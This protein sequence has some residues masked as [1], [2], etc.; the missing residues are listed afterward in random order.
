MSLYQFK[1]YPRF[2]LRSKNQHG[3]HSP[4]VFDLIHEVFSKDKRYYAFDEIEN[5]RKNLLASNTKLVVNDLG[6]GSQRM[7][8]SERSIGEIAKY[9]L[10]SAKYAQ[11]IFRLALKFQPQTILELGTS[12]GITT[13]YLSKACPQSQIITFE[14][15]PSIAQEARK[16][17]QKLAIITGKKN[18]VSIILGNMDQTLTETLSSIETVD[19]AFID[20]N[21]RK[22]PTINYAQQII[23]KTRPNSILILDDIYWSSEM[24]EAWEELKNH[25]KVTL[26]IDLFEKGILFFR[27]GIEKQHFYL[28]V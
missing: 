4:F 24:T 19:F 16:N 25:P 26:T 20:G 21:H 1:Q 10:T 15:A 17:L 2:L 22:E 7:K 8:N 27:E 14:G 11:I 23:D 13:A 5:L 12:L 3:I 9:S 28:R 18:K 6:A